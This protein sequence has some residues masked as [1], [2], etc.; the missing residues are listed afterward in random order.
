MSSEKQIFALNQP[1]GAGEILFSWQPGS[2]I[3]LATA[4]ADQS[5]AV[6]NRNGKLVERIRLRGICCGLGW[7]SDGDL[8]AMISSEA[9]LIVL[10]DANTGRKHQVDS[11][12]RDTMSCLLWS[13]TSPVLAIGSAK[14]NLT[15][16]NH[17]SVKRIPILGKHSKRITCGG[18]SQEGLLAL[19][20]E[21][22]SLSINNAE[23][24]TLRIINL[25]AEPSHV[26]FSE[27][28]LDERLGGENT[29]S[30]IV[31]H[32]TLFLYNL[33][34]PDNP[35]ELAFQNRYGS[36]ITYRWFGDGY[37]LLGFNAGYLVAISTHIKEVGQELFQAKNHRDT[38]SDIAL[39]T[40]LGH[41]ASGGDN[42]VKVHDMSNLQDTVTIHT[43]DSEGNVEH[44]A[45]S[46]DGQL[47]AIS[48]RNGNLVVYLSCLP[49]L[50]S[51][52]GTKIAALS[53][54]NEVTLYSYNFEKGKSS[55]LVVH[56]AIEPSFV[57]LG[58][59]HLCVG[60]NNRVWFYDL[61]AMTQDSG[62]APRLIKDKE[63]LGTITS[64]K[65]NAD[66][67]S[68]LHEGKIQLH[69]LE[70]SENGNENCE[71]KVFPDSPGQDHTITCHVLTNDFLIYTTD[72]G[73][74]FY[75]FIEDWK[76]VVEFRHSVGIRA[77]YPDLSGTKIVLYDAKSEGYLFNPVSNDLIKVPEFPQSCQ[78]VLWDIWPPD[79]NVFVAFDDKSIVTYVYVPESVHGTVIERVGVTRL[80]ANQVPLL[81]NS[82]VLVV[83]TVGGKL[84]QM[85]LST[86]TFQE[87]GSATNAGLQPADIE[88]LL[89]KHLMLRRFKEAWK[90]CQLLNKKENWIML[91]DA[92]LKSLDIDTALQVYRHI[93]NV[94]M[95]WSLEDIQNVEERKL[96]AGHVAMYLSL[97][98]LAQEWY[99]SSSD[100]SAALAMRRD[101]LQWE[102]A[103]QLA[104]NLAPHQ[105]PLI[106]KEYAQQLE[107]TGHHVE[108]L[109]HYEKGFLS[110]PSSESLTSSGALS[111]ELTEDAILMHNAECRAG[112]TRT[113]IRCG[114]IRRGV[115]MAM[116]SQSSKQLQKECAEILESQKQLSD[117]VNLYE[118]AEL[119][120]KAAS[121]YIQLKNWS[122]VGQ[123][124]P[125]ISSARIHLQFAKAKE[126]DR[127]Y[128]EA[129][130][131][132]EAAREWDSVIR[133]NLD[134]LNNPEK[135][136]RVV[137]ETKSMEGAKM[138]AKFFQK[139]N[140]YE[141]AIRFLVLS[142]C[143]DEAFQ[144][145]RRHN[146]LE[147][148][149]D[150]LLEMR[151]DVSSGA[152]ARPD[153]Y[154]SLALH[155]ENERNYFLAGKFYLHAEDYSK[156]L[157]HLLKVAQTNQEDQEAIPLA[158]EAVGAAKDERLATQLIEFLLGE[159]DGVVR[160]AK[161]LFQLY[162]ARQQFR[163]AAKTALIIANDEQVNGNYRHAHD[164]LLMMYQELR[165]R[166][167]HIPAEM[168][169]NLMLLHSYILVRLHVRRG[170]HLKGA[171][172]LIRVASN[173]SR[174]PSHI[175]PIFT[176]AVIECHRAG[177]KSFA[178]TYAAMLMRPEYRSQVDLKYQKKI[179]AVVRKPPKRNKLGEIEE[180]EEPATPCPFCNT[181]LT[182]T[183]LNCS[184]CKNTIPFC[185]ATGR[186]IVREDLTACPNC[187]FPAINTE[188][189]LIVE[190]GESC[191]MCSEKVN[192]DALSVVRDPQPYLY[193][194]G[195]EAILR[196]LEKLSTGA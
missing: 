66:Y 64:M 143:H 26:Q 130:K 163:E 185:I 32:K 175:V 44:V 51:V 172:M 141:S 33:H 86:H 191:P 79:K 94:A 120:E 72:M 139:L 164:V 160:D 135:A 170:D 25:R 113:S 119:F 169:N 3:Y 31:G 181:P 38:L 90:W 56:T 138:V 92:A 1:H 20:S 4:G 76:T 60:M 53:S 194:E 147:L 133:I 77:I 98:D 96:L 184:H 128:Y 82:G 152:E 6:Y 134:H 71:S 15:I 108:A 136:V 89:K 84:I 61:T 145:A 27:M 16:Y 8:L 78:G 13:K 183:E 122:K 85:V 35:V 41:V 195:G 146:Q 69:L 156:A 153:D 80:P 110:L 43:L 102:Q 81:L 30:V 182:E 116:D 137:Q 111:S 109:S 23:G 7:D 118:K 140:D 55:S 105:V 186:H 57:A 48:T 62:T 166:S 192:A 46:E 40:S 14:G 159:T 97:F 148:Y 91:A 121:C 132:Y 99:L 129:S 171:R 39:S 88:V 87:G 106:S 47:L 144:L 75:F 65:L 19:G 10:W 24:D 22:K 157:K 149:G 151:R 12:L 104:R 188:F 67:A 173:I 178:F 189:R 9:P 115:A 52:Y 50:A 42:T 100:P 142:H 162:M 45:W 168:V 196:G 74:L 103:L 58:P 117:A 114:D 29:V 17:S 5:V 101:L 49:M 112:V 179:E 131:A 73:D 158:I 70:P 165:Q 190:G 127:Q 125:K 187:D 95:V 83:Q 34:D 124:L 177:L 59:F 63:F 126:A 176:S 54:L 154:R 11:G 18:W 68:I 193:P 2:G 150:I 28:K 167:M 174:F 36:L 155:F 21:D 37:I 107:F 123:L 180:A 161:Y 93:K